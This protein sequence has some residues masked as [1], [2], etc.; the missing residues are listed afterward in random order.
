[1]KKYISGKLSLYSLIGYL[2]PFGIYISDLTYKQYEQ[3]NRFIKEKIHEYKKDFA[4]SFKTYRNLHST[5]GRIKYGTSGKGSG[6]VTEMLDI[7]QQAGMEDNIKESVFYNG[8]DME[9]RIKR[10]YFIKIRNI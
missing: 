8:Y 4:A 2:E 10:R 6:M 9:E 3:M 7:K 1:M 5:R